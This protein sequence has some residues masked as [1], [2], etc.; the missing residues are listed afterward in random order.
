[1]ENKI[2]NIKER[3]LQVAV[4]YGVSKEKFFQ[5]IGMTYGNFK[6][7]SKETPLNSNAII[8]ILT[9]YPD[10]NADWLLSGDGFM[11]RGEIDLIALKARIMNFADEY[12]V[13]RA[14]FFGELGIAESDFINEAYE[15]DSTMLSKL[16]QMNNMIDRDWLL[17]GQGNIMM[18]PDNVDIVN[19]VKD[20]EKGY[21]K[22]ASNERDVL[23]AKL[24]G[25]ERENE[26]L[27]EM[28][29]ILKQSRDNRGEMGGDIKQVG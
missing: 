29:D 12:Y 3:V 15:V 4:F 13:S 10:I 11:F 22:K 5:N 1:M 20:L 14:Q 7:K 27:R 8:D 2:T 23:R 24:E 16:A 19:E 9:I 28:V 25:L 18:Y 26:L 17:T 6:G 21:D